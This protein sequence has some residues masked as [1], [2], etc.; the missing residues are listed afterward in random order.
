MFNGKARLHLHAEQE[1]RGYVNVV[2]T[3]KAATDTQWAGLTHFYHL[4]G[5]NVY[6]LARLNAIHV[7]LY[8]NCVFPYV[9]NIFF[10]ESVNKKGVFYYL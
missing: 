6:D 4:T 8:R 2:G 7:I 10:D 1:A 5:K 3:K 9:P